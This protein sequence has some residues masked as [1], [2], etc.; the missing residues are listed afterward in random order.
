SGSADVLAALGVNLEAEPLVLEEA[1]RAAHICFMM[2]PKHHGA[3]RHVAGARVELGTRTI[4][5]I[6]GPLSNPAGVR[7]QLVG[8]FADRWLTPIAEVLGKL[9]SERAWVVHGSDGLDE[10]TLTGPTHVAELR[11]GRVRRFEVTP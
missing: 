3:M 7:R 10:L 8:V 1:L 6:L 2:A 4:F 5:N 11:E 9:G